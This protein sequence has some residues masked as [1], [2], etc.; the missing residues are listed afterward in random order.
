M[1]IRYIVTVQPGQIKARVEVHT[2]TGKTIPCGEFDSVEQ[3]VA[4]AD[5]GLV[6]NAPASPIRWVSEWLESEGGK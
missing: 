2:G 6:R 1:K 5:Q 3:A 4:F